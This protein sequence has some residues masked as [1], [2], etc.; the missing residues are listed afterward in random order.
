VRLDRKEDEPA[1]IE[2]F[3]SFKGAALL[4]VIIDQDACVYTMVGTGHP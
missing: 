3:L 1:V 2:Q 4:E